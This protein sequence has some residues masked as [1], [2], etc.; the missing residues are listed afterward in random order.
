MIWVLGGWQR[1]REGGIEKEERKEEG[2]EGRGG[3]DW[4]P[5]SSLHRRLLLDLH[6]DRARTLVSYAAG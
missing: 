5:K 4:E 1:G 6:A 3:Q 2:G